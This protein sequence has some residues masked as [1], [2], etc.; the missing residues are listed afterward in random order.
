MEVKIKGFLAIF[1]CISG[2][3]LLGFILAPSQLHVAISDPFERRREIVIGRFGDR[4][5]DSIEYDLVSRKEALIESARDRIFIGYIPLL[6]YASFARKFSTTSYSC[7]GEEMDPDG[8]WVVRDQDTVA[9]VNCSYVKMSA[10]DRFLST[11]ARR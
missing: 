5:S 3:V 6:A 1:A 7:V 9:W 4:R 11:I 8:Y 10:L 2:A